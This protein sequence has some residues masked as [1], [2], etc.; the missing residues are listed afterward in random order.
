MAEDHREVWRKLWREKADGRYRWA[1][2]LRWGE[3]GGGT[4]RWA[5]SGGS[6]VQRCEKAMGRNIGRSYTAQALNET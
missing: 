6:L 5:R 1:G 4:V 3:T 2:N